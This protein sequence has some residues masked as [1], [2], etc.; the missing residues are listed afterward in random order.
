[1]SVFLMFGVLRVLQQLGVG[2]FS[3]LGHNS[4]VFCSASRSQIKWNW[5]ETK[6]KHRASPHLSFRTLAFL[7]VKDKNNSYCPMQWPL[8]IYGISEDLGLKTVS[9][10]SSNML[11]SLDSNRCHI[12]CFKGLCPLH[13]CPAQTKRHGRLESFPS[14]PDLATQ[15]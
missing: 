3:A 15:K 1:M 6:I 5:D 10:G 9:D 8:V 7:N 12:F 14:L 13:T 2:K 4:D 11:P